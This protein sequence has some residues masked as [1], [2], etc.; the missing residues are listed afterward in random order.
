MLE[1]PK[2]LVLRFSSIGDIVLTTPVIRCLK[3]QLDAE[4]DFLTKCEYKDLII[5]NPNINEVLTLSNLSKTIDI[6]RRKD[7]DFVID[8]QKNILS[9]KIRLALRVKSY[10]FSKNNFKRYLLIYF[11]IN[12]LNDHIVD[13]YFKAVK[14]LNVYNDNNGIDYFTNKT[15]IDF[16]VEQDYICWCLSGSYENKRLSIKQIKNI[17]SK[18]HIPVLLIGGQA[19]KDSSDRII[20]SIESKNVFNLCGET[21]INESAFFIK[22]SKLFLTN[23]TGMMHIASAFSMPII[24]FWGCTKPSL[25]FSAYLPNNKSKNIISNLSERPCSK[26]GSYCRVQSEGCIKEI[27]ENVIVEAIESLLK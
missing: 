6:L 22:K 5:L 4:I 2:I 21:T 8:L 1:K 25:G 17:I 23:D 13:R 12:L 19:E 10:T 18:L 11:G 24:S 16:N 26:H 9:L 15:N 7:Y 27:D 3:L 20:N 14:K